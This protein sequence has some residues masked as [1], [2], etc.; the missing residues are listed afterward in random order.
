MTLKTNWSVDFWIGAALATLVAAGF[1]ISQASRAQGAPQGAPSV[2]SSP[3][4]SVDQTLAHGK[5]LTDA[6]NCMTCHTQPGSAPFSGGVPFTT[7]LGKI[8]SS[9][10]TPDNATGIGKWSVEDF[11]RALHDGIAPAGRHLFPAFPYTSFTKISDADVAAIYAY[12]RSVRPVHYSPPAN[13]FV[14]RQ[15]WGMMFWNLMF[16]KSQRFA[17]DAKHSAEW[18]RGAYLVEGLGHCDACHSPRNFFMAEIASQAYSGG[19]LQEKVVGGQVHRWS[20]VNLTSAKTGLAAWSVDNLARYLK[21]GVSPR[22]GVFGPMNDVVDKSLRNL[23]VEDIHAMAIY[24][25]SLPP[26]GSNAAAPAEAAVKSGAKIYGDHCEEC[27]MSSG[28]GGF[29]S[30]PPLAGSAVVQANDPASLINIILYGPDE[31]KDISLGP[32]ETMKPY[33]DVLSDAAVASVSNYVRGSWK[34]R[35]SAVS[36]ADVARQRRS[37]QIR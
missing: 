1:L 8:Y 15:R 3:S 12:L 24:L 2:I 17:P 20:G 32:W 11:R 19:V 9:N 26:R 6:G 37:T 28:R 36:P 16:F 10:I 7:K 34:N 4:G 33:K 27:H 25:K 35:A 31:P 14:F 29:L 13:D 22:A 5:Y 21:T 30:A 18:N 23:S